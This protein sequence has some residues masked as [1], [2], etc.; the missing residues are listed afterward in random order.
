MA[1]LQS[2]YVPWKGY[3]DLIHDV[4]L[5]VFYDDVQFTARDWRSRNRIKTPSGPQWLT[6]P[7]GHDREWRICDVPLPQSDWARVHGE[8]LVAS[9]RR[10]ANF[11]RYAPWLEEFYRRD[12]RLLSEFNQALITE[13]ARRFLGIETAI[14]DSRDFPV[15]GRGQERL[16]NLLSALG[17]STYVS[18]PAAKAYIEE[19]R[20]ASSGVQI[21][22]KDYRGYPEYAQLYPPFLHEVSILDLLFHV[23]PAAADYIW[24]WRERS[25]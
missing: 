24:G 22:W 23:G 20:F 6:I 10:A 9:Y 1:V 11:R 14:R 21:I 15:N 8:R 19:S 3:F 12:W 2:S 7:V 16:L 18:G 13:V 25:L 4:D 17:A 5:F